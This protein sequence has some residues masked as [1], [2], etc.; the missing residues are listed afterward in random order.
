MCTHISRS[1]SILVLV[2]V[3][4]GAALP[5]TNV[6]TYPQLAAGAGT[7]AQSVAAPELDRKVF[8]PFVQRPLVPII[9]VPG[10][11]GTQLKDA[12]NLERWPALGSAIPSLYR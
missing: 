1:V 11:G 7:S 12:N 10:T 4:L 2:V 9:F 3:V 5:N 6:F 8:L